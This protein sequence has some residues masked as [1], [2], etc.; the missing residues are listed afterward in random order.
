MKPLFIGKEEQNYHSRN[1][2]DSN[3]NKGSSGS[4]RKY[5]RSPYLQSFFFLI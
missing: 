1:K 4:L 3:S 5:Q 2:D